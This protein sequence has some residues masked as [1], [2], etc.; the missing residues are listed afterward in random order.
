[1]SVLAANVEADAM[2]MYK[3]IYNSVWNGGSAA[4]YNKILDAA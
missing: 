1:M 2:N 3:D 4:S